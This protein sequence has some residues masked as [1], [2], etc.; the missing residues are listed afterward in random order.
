M[1]GTYLKFQ[2]FE[3]WQVVRLIDGQEYPQGYKCPT[4][5]L[6]LTQFSIDQG[7]HPIYISLGQPVSSNIMGTRIDLIP[8][9]KKI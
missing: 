8:G 7:P 3:G 1:N 6:A 5:E 4:I 2:Q 9:V